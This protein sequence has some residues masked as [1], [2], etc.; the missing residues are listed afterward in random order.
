MK[1]TVTTQRLSLIGAIT[2]ASLINLGCA[3]NAQTGAGVGATLACV[4][5]AANAPRGKAAQECAKYAIVGA[6]VGYWV[7]LQMDAQEAKLAAQRIKNIGGNDV[8]VALRTRMVA[9]PAEARGGALANTQAIEVVDE[10]VV[11]VP[12]SKLESGEAAT[13][14]QLAEAGSVVSKANRPHQVFVSSKT[15]PIAQTAVTAMQG[16]YTTPVQAGKVQYTYAEETRSPK[17]TI[18][19]VPGPVGSS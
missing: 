2:A 8:D 9:V 18:R 17:T 7:G 19:I 10:F 4:L 16:G 6:A 12:T 15:M 14:K 13:V 11:S 1:S 5:A 3:T